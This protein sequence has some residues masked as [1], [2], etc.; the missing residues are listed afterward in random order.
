MQ[1]GNLAAASGATSRV[2][3]TADVLAEILEAASRHQRA[4]ARGAA[5]THEQS[6]HAPYQASSPSEPVTLA[7]L[8][9][10]NGA[11][12]VAG[13][14][15]DLLGRAPDPGALD[16]YRTALL[17]G[18][19]PKVA[20]LGM[21]RYS[22]EGRRCG[23]VVPGLRRR[24]LMQRAYRVPLLGRALRTAAAVLT[25]PR[26]MRDLQRLEQQGALDRERIAQLEQALASAGS[27]GR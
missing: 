26:L 3:T 7:R 16:L 1:Q 17:S 25:L 21:L 22:R 2:L 24:F 8:L 20:I 4:V 9:E 14:Y 13:A 5:G 27:L 11:D 23:R 15:A 18:T 10:R 19:L 6:R 12:F